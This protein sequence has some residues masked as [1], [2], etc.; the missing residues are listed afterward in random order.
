MEKFIIAVDL[1]E[2]LLGDNKVVSQ[3][4]KDALNKCK[5]LG[6]IIAI[7]STRGYGSCER[8]AKEISADYVCCHSGNMIVK[9]DT[10]EI[11]YQKPFQKA[12]FQEMVKEFL[13]LTQKI[14]IDSVKGLYGDIDVQAPE[15]KDLVDTWGVKHLSLNEMLEKEIFKVCVWYEDSYK[16]KIIDFCEKKNYI[17][18]PMRGNN[19]MLI[20][21]KDSDKFYAL[22]KL[23]EL[24]E[25]NISNIVVFGDD[26]SDA[27][28]IEKSGYGVAMA[29]ARESVL[30]KAKYVTS[31]N[32]DDGVACFLEDLFN[33]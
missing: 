33:F 3:R 9:V 1:D 22:K 17:C 11:I 16:D 2:T 8:I 4:N 13:P 31:S 20:T 25:I 28:S 6:F 29:N 12:E 27:L 32:N 15:D 24:F 7:S 5:E 23:A 14:I 19:F 21:Q 10:E 26:D 18:R 30:K